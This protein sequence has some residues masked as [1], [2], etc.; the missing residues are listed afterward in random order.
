M[1]LVASRQ[2]IRWRASTLSTGHISFHANKGQVTCAE[3]TDRLD[4]KVNS[5]IPV[6]K[7][8]LQYICNVMT[9]HIYIY[10]STYVYIHVYTCVNI[11]IYVCIYIHT[12]IHLYIYIYNFDSN[13]PKHNSNLP[14]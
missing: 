14:V 1:V 4:Q 8:D 2:L 11:N 9:I 5:K 13:P 7:W 6:T 10:I 3:N 12:Y